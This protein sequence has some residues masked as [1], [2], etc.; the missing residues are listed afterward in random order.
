MQFTWLLLLLPL[1]LLLFRTPLHPKIRIQLSH[2]RSTPAV[3]FTLSFIPRRGIQPGFISNCS[4]PPLLTSNPFLYSIND[5]ALVQVYALF[6][7]KTGNAFRRLNMVP[8]L[9]ETFQS[10]YCGWQDLEINSGT[11]TA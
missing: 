8:I 1:L 2:F 6:H 5:T 11:H 7:V 10:L 3:T 9:V 4:P